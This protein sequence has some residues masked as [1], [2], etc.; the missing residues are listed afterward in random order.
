MRLSSNYKLKTY[1][2]W[3]IYLF[4]A[5]IL[6]FSTK[7]IFASSRIASDDNMKNTLLAGDFVLFEK[8]GK[9]ERGNI[10]S[11][12]VGM[13]N[14]IYPEGQIVARCIAVGGQRLT[15]VNGIGLRRTARPL[16]LISA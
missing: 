4:Y 3:Y 14:E 10:V 2:K 6:I 16:V 5:M 9:I 12:N 15:T 7:I 8:L 13:G 1:N 11:F